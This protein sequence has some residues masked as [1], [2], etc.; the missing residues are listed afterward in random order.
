MCTPAFLYLLI[1]LRKTS[2]DSSVV[3]V[4]LLATVIRKTDRSAMASVAYASAAYSAAGGK[5]R[6]SALSKRGQLKV[7]MKQRRPLPKRGQ[8]KAAIFASW[9]KTLG[10]VLRLEVS[11]V[12]N[13]ASGG[14]CC[15]FGPLAFQKEL[16]VEEEL[17]SQMEECELLL[18]R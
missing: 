4:L 13:G 1:V 11:C 10:R 15:G 8:V 5:Q 12:P 7:A 16:P 6:R 2:R 3:V 17:K 18:L 14:A 9:L